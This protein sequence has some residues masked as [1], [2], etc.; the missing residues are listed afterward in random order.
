MEVKLVIENKFNEGYLR[1]VF[2]ANKTGPITINRDREIG[3]FIY[4]LSKWRCIPPKQTI[5]LTLRLPVLNTRND[6]KRFYYLTVEDQSKINDYINA[7]FKNWLDRCL[8]EGIYKVGLN[9][10]DVIDVIISELS[11]T[12]DSTEEQKI[13]ERLA[14]WDYRKRMDTRKILIKAM[15][16]IEI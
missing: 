5:G 4:G 1:K 8:I 7:N 15:Q 6:E 3:K 10:K 11:L 12:L 16:N 9:R 14:K 2:N 13:Y